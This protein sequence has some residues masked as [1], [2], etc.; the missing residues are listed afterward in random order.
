M[1]RAVWSQPPPGAAGAMMRTSSSAKAVVDAKFE[2]TPKARKRA[3]VLDNR[4][5]RFI[6]FLHLCRCRQAT[7]FSRPGAPYRKR[8][9]ARILS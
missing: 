5:L 2:Q 6:G 9:S 1:A 4:F 8:V 3:A 7:I